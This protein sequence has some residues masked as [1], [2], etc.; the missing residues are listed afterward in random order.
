LADHEYNTM[1]ASTTTKRA[2]T[3]MLS[4]VASAI[5]QKMAD[6]FG[7][8]A[9]KV[10]AKPV[11]FLPSCAVCTIVLGPLMIAAFGHVE[12]R[13]SRWFSPPKSPILQHESQ[14][15]QHFHG[16]RAETFI[17]RADSNA[18]DKHH[19]LE[20]MTVHEILSTMKTQPVAP[21]YPPGGGEQQWNFGQLCLPQGSACA[22]SSILNVWGR[23]RTLL[24]ARSQSEILA[25]INGAP[26]EIFG[27][28]IGDVLGGITR[29]A[30]DDNI[31]SAA[32]TSTI[33]FLQFRG[34]P[35]LAEPGPLPAPSTDLPA[36]AWETMFVQQLGPGG[37]ISAATSLRLSYQAQN[38]LIMEYFTAFISEVALVYIGLF[39]AFIYTA[40]IFGSSFPKQS[41][42]RSRS[43]MT[44]A[45]IATW[46]M[47]VQT[48]FGISSL[49]GQFV[50][51][52]HASV[53]LILLVVCIH[54]THMIVARFNDECGFNLDANDSIGQAAAMERPLSDRL[55][56]AMRR[57]GVAIT[58]TSATNCISFSVGVASSVPILSSICFFSAVGIF[59]C[60]I[61]TLTFFT[62][63][64]ALDDERQARLRRDCCPCCS[65]TE[66][67]DTA[68]I[69]RKQTVLADFIRSKYAPFLMQTGVRC[70]V[71]ILCGIML[72]A[73]VVSITQLQQR[74][75]WRNFLVEG[76]YLNDYVA[77]H[78]ATFSEWD[79]YYPVDVYTFGTSFV[80]ADAQAV[81]VALASSSWIDSDSVNSWF[82]SFIV[83]YPA[84]LNIS[85]HTDFDATVSAWLATDVGLPYTNDIIFNT[86][87]EIIA[88][89]VRAKYS[90]TQVRTADDK[91]K[92]MDGLRDEIAAVTKSTAAFPFEYC[93]VFW[94]NFKVLVGEARWN[95]A[96]ATISALVVVGCLIGSPLIGLLVTAMFAWTLVS[97]GLFDFVFGLD[98]NVIT[99]STL[100]FAIGLSVEYSVH[101]GH[102][103]MLCG[104]GDRIARVVQCLNEIGTPVCHAFLS[105]LM[106]TLPLFFASTFSV[107]VL[108]KQ[109][110]A[111]L[112]FGFI[113][114]F[115]LLPVSILLIMV[116]IMP[117]C[118]HGEHICMRGM[119]VM[120]SIVGPEPFAR[121][122]RDCERRVPM[123]ART[124]SGE[125]ARKHNTNPLAGTVGDDT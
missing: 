66:D 27:R 117:H 32:A 28:Q 118:T 111:V 90:S 40:V 106:F 60:Y 57:A 51:P 89:R 37:S 56:F 86:E 81:S 33:M 83:V 43:C 24:E 55:K 3:G 78:D 26:I 99:M 123:S 100:V 41:V 18:L 120:L 63:C 75:T 70:G 93:F 98:M 96:R 38:S 45:A 64:L 54:D 95:C 103:F 115:A 125:M 22:V 29:S 9:A 110:F 68:A 105:T 47:S 77:E 2:S 34:D 36:E 39:L 12:F 10:A 42:V 108:F 25:D 14:V 4:D 112:I 97:L 19:L 124:E 73:G 61:F 74:W 92:A 44:L 58:V 94:E 50:T 107:H 114:G 84:A 21:T 91:A 65:A 53:V 82:S 119:Q 102:A 31:V 35:T 116:W 7:S 8:L 5:D 17:A 11:P 49:C 122:E 72:I 62:A 46:I 113:Y 88:T 79:E 6:M 80:V 69:S 101:F 23:N 121:S 87:G 52:I 13:M 16:Q 15:R 59:C 71:L 67:I 20:L 48:S 30:A 85:T 109:L 1:A 76:S 104:E